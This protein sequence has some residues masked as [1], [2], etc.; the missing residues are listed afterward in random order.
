VPTLGVAQ[1]NSSDWYPAYWI[2]KSRHGAN[3]AAG[4][5]WN[6]LYMAFNPK[7][8]SVSA[9]ANGLCVLHLQL[10]LPVQTVTT[11]PTGGYVTSGNLSGNFIQEPT[12]LN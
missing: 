12:L 11:F 2:F 9:D 4:G 6:E 1:N 5:V 10:R 3:G 7:W 8:Y